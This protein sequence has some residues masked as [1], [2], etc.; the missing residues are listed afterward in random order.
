MLTELNSWGHISAVVEMGVVWVF[1]PNVGCGV[2]VIFSIAQPE[3][4]RIA[5]IENRKMLRAKRFIQSP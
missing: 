1:V 2:F 3:S 4:N 5:M